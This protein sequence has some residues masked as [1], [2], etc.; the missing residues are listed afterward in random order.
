MEMSLKILLLFLMFFA[1]FIKISEETE[2]CALVNTCDECKASSGCNWCAG[3][4]VCL[5]IG[6]SE[7][8]SVYCFG[9]GGSWAPTTCPTT[10]VC[11]TTYANWTQCQECISSGSCGWCAVPGTGGACRQKGF[12]LACGVIDG[13]WDNPNTCATED[14]NYCFGYSDCETCFN[15]TRCGWCSVGLCLLSDGSSTCTSVGGGTW[16]PC[17]PT[18]ADPTTGTT[19]NPTTK[20]PTTHNPTS[21]TTKNPTTKNPTTGTT[22]NPTTGTTSNPTTGTTGNPT[23]G[24][25]QNP[26]TGTIVDPTTQD[27]TTATT[28]NPTTENPTTHDPTTG[29]TQ[30]PTTQNPTTQN[31]TTGT[32]KDP[33]TGT[34]HNPTTATTQMNPSTQ[35]PTTESTD[36]VNGAAK[37][38]LF[39]ELFLIL[40][41][42]LSLLF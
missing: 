24:T 21:G 12:S 37:L 11:A 22:K 33:T 30:N 32:T 38:T 13:T 28:Q 39:Y 4:G 7:P 25:I 16:N 20:N 6:G 3:V 34:T 18:T 10:E 5:D 42:I 8:G 40:I 29:T 35:N 23:T 2:G 31:P 1:G 9:L 41:G 17:S 15:D 19:K 36:S 27:P 26:T 14:P